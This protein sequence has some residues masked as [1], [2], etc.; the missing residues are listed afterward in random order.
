MA[1][2]SIEQDVLR[3]VASSF[4]QSADRLRAQ[5][6]VLASLMGIQNDR[7]RENTDAVAQNTSSRGSAVSSAANAG[8]SILNTIGGGLLLSPLISGIARLFRGSRQ[9]E[10]PPLVPAARPQSLALDAA[11][12]PGL[13]L[14]AY[15]F[16]QNG[17]PREISSPRLRSAS[18]QATQ[19]DPTGI[20]PSQANVTIQIQA[21]DSR[22]ILDRS[23]D[24]AKALREAMLHS[25]SVNDVINEA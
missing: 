7:I 3:V 2:T 21:L 12:L 23:D 11:I 14:G 20:R 15:D 4:P 10:P 18:G 25:H 5:A 9:D 24:I 8:R 1:R 22:S 16:D 13:R 19:V 17:R 6:E